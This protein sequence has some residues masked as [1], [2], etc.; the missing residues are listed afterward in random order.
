MVQAIRLMG[1]IEEEVDI[2]LDRVS[3]NNGTPAGS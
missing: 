3:L 1:Q 2:I